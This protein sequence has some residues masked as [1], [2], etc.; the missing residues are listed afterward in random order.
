[1]AIELISEIVQKNGQPFPLIDANNIRGGFYQTNTIAERDAIPTARKKDG[2]LCFVK[3]DPQEIHTYQWLNSKWNKAK[4]GSGGVEVVNSKTNLSSISGLEIGQLAFTKDDDT[5]RIYT[6]KGWEVL[7]GYIISESEPEDKSLLWIDPT[8]DAELNN[9]GNLASV[10]DSIAK[11]QATVSKLNKI[12]TMGVIAGDAIE[13]ARTNIMGQ[14]DTA[15][16]PTDPDDSEEIEPNKSDALQTVPNISIK[17][18]TMENFT[19]NVN[20]L[21]DGELIWVTTTIDPTNEASTIAVNQLYVYY[22]G[23]FFPAGNGSSGDGGGGGGTIVNQIT[24]E[25]IQNFYFDHL[26][27]NDSN[28]TRYR[29]E[30]TENGTPLIYNSANRDGIMGNPGSYGSYIS[31]YLRIN[32]IFIGGVKTPLDSFSACSHN[33]VELGNGS[34]NDINL[35]GLYLLY[36]IPNGSSWESIAL[37]G[38]IK[39]GSTFLIR[40]ARCSYKSN[41]TIDVDDFDL[42][43]RD[44][45]NNLIQFNEGGGTFYLVCSQNNQFYTGSDWVT[46]DYFGSVSPYQS[47]K[48]I[49]GYVDLVGI[50][51]P[52]KTEYAVHAEGGNPIQIKTTE[53][54]KDCIFVRS[55]TLDPCSQAQKAHA[56]KKSSA[57]WTYINMKTKGSDI[58]PYYSMIDKFRY[59]PKAS[60]YNKTIYGT[61]TTFDETKPNIINITFGIQATDN[62]A[63]ATRCFNWISLGEYDE[64]IE[65]KKSS[66]QW[67]QAL[68]KKSI[69]E[70]NYKT[71]YQGDN[72]VNQFIKIYKRIKWLTT[73]LTVVTT[74]KVILRG[75][76][77]GTYNYRIRRVDDDSYISDEYTFTVR[78]DSAVNSSFSFAHTSDQ[79]A[80]N[81]Y[82][83]QAWT[84]AAYAINKNHSGIHFTINTGDISQNGNRESEWLDY[85]NGR[86]FLESKEE[87]FT[88]G[89]NDLCGKVV[90]QLGNGSA[91][92]YKINHKNVVYYYTFELDSNN[93]QLFKFIQNG[94]SKD[95]YGEDVISYDDT[96]FTYYMPSLYSFNYGNYHFIS[97]NSEF[98]NNTG[99]VYYTDGSKN[100][101]IMM[102][103]Y[104]NMYKWLQKDLQLYP[105]KRYIV[106][107]H[108]I[109]FCITVANST[110][111]VAEARTQDSGSK[112]NLDFTNGKNYTQ[113][114]SSDTASYKG[115]CSFSEF[116]QNNNIK[117]V[118]GGHKHTYSLSYPTK[119][120]ITGSGANRTV[121]YNNPIVDKT[122]TN[123]VIYEMC[124]ATG[125]KLVSNKELPGTGITWLKKYFPVIA[126]G[127]ANPQQYYPTYVL[128]TNTNNTL[129]STSYQVDNI[130]KVVNNSITN[131]NINNQNPEFSTSNSKAITDTS[132]NI[133]Y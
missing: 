9:E 23:S 2:M 128:Y 79:Q 70:D 7:K 122:G 75:L 85:H 52:G 12:L 43:W 104:Y 131:F 83:Y 29:F 64:Y 76:S 33:F 38:T 73:N 37:K 114:G 55:F 44:S 35:N 97:L 82:E 71:E 89:N 10:R 127:K 111:G 93:T 6:S 77:A 81:F 92:T 34:T 124:Q 120:R 19:N 27:F 15:T 58:D 72:N 16:N 102:H 121:E 32:S 39:A 107:A 91:G 41:I 100:N 95:L 50:R 46:I 113:G 59:V 86:R 130:Y 30:I 112:L 67:S 14:S 119:E 24:K 80:F 3:T 25:D 11:L 61:R 62:G 66:E 126:A 18:D 117:L 53:D 116:F 125:Y 123:G 20:N 48:D 129:A 63:G 105:N 99:S 90:Y 108:E 88:I 84:K 106:F 1:M 109:P 68:T 94:L 40:G 110:T 65:Y 87:M 13:S 74:H 31:D 132:F 4:L 103:A 17:M 133:T 22:K 98:A 49:K 51:A 54:I 56:S 36:K 78:T 57:L 60:K 26:G 42:E 47:D 21:I 28:G 118:L 69:S 96:S 115:G 45:S 5:L 101:D 8:G